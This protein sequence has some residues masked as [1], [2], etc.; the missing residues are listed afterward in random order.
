[1]AALGGLLSADH[2][3]GTESDLHMIP[4]AI[5]NRVRVDIACGGC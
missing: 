2:Y 4:D 1:M 3:D 5:R